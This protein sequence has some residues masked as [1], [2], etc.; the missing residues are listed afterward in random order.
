MCAQRNRAEEGGDNHQATPLL[1]TH[2][3]FPPSLPPSLPSLPPCLPHTMS[4][5][6]DH[7][8]AVVPCP[9]LLT[10][11]GAMYSTVPQNEYVLESNASLLRPKSVGG[12]RGREREEKGRGRFLYFLRENK[13]KSVGYKVRE[14]KWLAQRNSVTTGSATEA[15]SQT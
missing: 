14:L 10:T 9:F 2:P 13:T 4:T 5:P 15:H 12:E 3:S 1:P 11:S 7:Q 6:K 8:S